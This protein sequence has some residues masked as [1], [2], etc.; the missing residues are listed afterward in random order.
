MSSVANSKHFTS[1]TAWISTT[2]SSIQDTWIVILEKCWTRINMYQDR[3]LCNRS[4]QLISTICWDLNPISDLGNLFRTIHGAS[5]WCSCVRVILILHQ[6]ILLSIIKWTAGITSITSTTRSAIKKLLWRK[7]KECSL[8]NEV[9][10]FNGFRYCK[11]PRCPTNN[12]H[13]F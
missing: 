9:F 3:L 4:Y 13:T 12:L 11:T 8:L 2:S 1:C 7:F 6:R 5:F 10:S